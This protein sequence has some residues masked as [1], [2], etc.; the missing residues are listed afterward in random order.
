M[1]RRG[2]VIDRLRHPTEAVPHDLGTMVRTV[3]G[4]AVLIPAL[5]LASAV[6]V[7]L[8]LLRA[9]RRFIDR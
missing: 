6:V 8:A 9:P 5:L 7:T 2:E 1:G 4:V 3:V